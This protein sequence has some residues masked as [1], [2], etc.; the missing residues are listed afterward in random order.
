V[1]YEDIPCLQVVELVT[2][3]L[4]GKLAT[5]EVLVVERHLAMCQGCGDYLDQMRETIRAT[6]ALRDQDVPPEVMEPLMQ[7]FRNL[8]R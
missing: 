5:G 4:E 1:T 8:R 3:Y 6:G 7:A 2:D